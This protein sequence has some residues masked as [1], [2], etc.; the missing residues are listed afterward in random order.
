MHDGDVETFADASEL[1]CLRGPD[2]VTR[3]RAGAPA[4]TGAL[5]RRSATDARACAQTN[6]ANA[7]GPTHQSSRTNITTVESTI[8]WENNR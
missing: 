7:V 8:A 4:R 5:V 6:C 2:G 1:R 3:P